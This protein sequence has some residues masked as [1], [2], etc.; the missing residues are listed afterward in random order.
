MTVMVLAASLSVG[1]A[2]TTINS[3]NQYAYGANLGWLDCRGD[4][5]NGAGIGEYV[6]SGSI[7]AANVG[8]I[9]LGTGSPTN[10]L[11]YQNLS[12]DDCGVNHDGLGNLRGYAYSANIGWINFETN[13]AA[14]V[15]LATGKFSGSIYSANCGWIS[16]SNSFAFVQT[17]T[18]ASGADTDGD[19]IPDAWELT[20][21]N[22][23][24]AFSV[25]SDAD[26]DGVSD[27]NEYLA[28]TDPN[29]PA[30][31][32]RITSNSVVF[33]GANDSDAL[34]WTSEPTRQYRVQ[35][36]T[37]L[38][39]NSSWITLNSLFGPDTGLSRTETINLG[40]SSPQRFFRVE[41][42]KPL[43]P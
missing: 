32:L 27:W 33:F 35:Y 14:K 17:D 13:G 15:D 1:A 25:T 10:G 40:S 4:T 30:K 7:Y 39:P 2:A 38:D 37:S 22:T 28:D 12:A 18:M 24:T 26:G 41:A 16:L 5:I 6:C 42:I 43:S 36:R 21:T 8:W 34:T 20:H 9:N 29:D 19:G 31:Q 11:R 23:L 3:G